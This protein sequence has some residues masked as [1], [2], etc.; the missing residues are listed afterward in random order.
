PQR[1]VLSLFDADQ[2]GVAQLVNAAL[3]SEH[4]R[5]RHLDMLE[6]S[7]FQFAFDFDAALYFFDLHD[8]G[9][10][11]PAQQLRQN[12]AGLRIAVIIGLQAGKD[13]IE[14]L[15]LDSSG[16]RFGGV[17]GVERNEA[18]ILQL[19]GVVGALG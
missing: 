7:R 16:E 13:E 18:G 2:G 1:L 11:R 12:N 19:N 10:V 14:F 17:D 4:R 5:Q 3:Y 6:I 8:D 15:V 9:G